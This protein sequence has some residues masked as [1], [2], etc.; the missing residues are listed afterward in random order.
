MGSKHLTFLHFRGINEVKSSTA[1][2]GNEGK[3]MRNKCE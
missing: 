3:V 2:G 1:T